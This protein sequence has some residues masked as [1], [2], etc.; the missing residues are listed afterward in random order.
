MDEP[1]DN[2]PTPWLT[3]PEAAQR[4]RVGAK[5]IYSEIRAGRLR[6]A[7]VGGRR[8]IRIRAVWVDSWLDQASTPVEVRQ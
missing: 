3:V 1:K 8:D 2:T 4:A 5:A 6:A 7:R